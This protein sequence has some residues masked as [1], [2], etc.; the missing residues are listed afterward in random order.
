MSLFTGPPAYLNLVITRYIFQTGGLW[1]LLNQS[2][3]MFFL[4]LGFVS[5]DFTELRTSNL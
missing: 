2:Y 1:P 3:F 5:T 4:D